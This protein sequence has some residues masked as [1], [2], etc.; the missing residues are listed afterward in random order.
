MRSRARS[1]LC[2]GVL[3][4]LASCAGNRKPEPEIRYQQVPVAVAA[5]CV[6]DRPAEIA[7][8]N[9]RVPSGEWAARA[10]GAKAATVEE[11]A[12]MRLNYE[13]RLAAAVAGCKAVTAPPTR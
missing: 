2:C 4:L 1:S 9:V 10:P 12:G 6:V 13:A 11:Q 8:M 3:T 7:A 5:P